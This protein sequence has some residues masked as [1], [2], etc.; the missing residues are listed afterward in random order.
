MKSSRG[1][2]PFG[3]G[4]PVKTGL[5][6]KVREYE[7]RKAAKAAANQARLKQEFLQR[8]AA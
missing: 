6:Q 8:R 1:T 5:A 7:Q 4:R 2:S 3:H